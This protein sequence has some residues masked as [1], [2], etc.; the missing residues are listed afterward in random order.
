M[1]RTKTKVEETEVKKKTTRKIKAEVKEEPVHDLSNKYKCKFCGEFIE[2]G[3]TICPSCRK[4]NKS[5]ANLLVFGSIA[6]IMLFAIIFFHFVNKYIMN[7][8]NKDSFVQECTL[9]TYEDL[10]RVPKTYM[11]KNV[12]VI[13]RVVD[14]QG[15]NDGFY[16]DMT[17]TLDLNL[18]DDGIENLITV[19]FKD[20]KFEQGFIS[21][22]LLVVYAEYDT[23]NGNEPL[24]NAKYI[25][26][27]N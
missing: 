11:G 8:E 2:N 4:S 26:F 27:K 13:G 16:N 15:Y 20:S 18:F 14:V 1:P 23:I 9:V 12:A 17:I 7:P 6:A 5:N 22:D 19:N 24:L 21:G 10:V 3:M 25:D